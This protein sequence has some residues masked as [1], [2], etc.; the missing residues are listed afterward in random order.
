MRSRAE[1]SERGV[2]ALGSDCLARSMKRFL[3]S[4]EEGSGEMEKEV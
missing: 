1:E 3:Q 4:E 2:K